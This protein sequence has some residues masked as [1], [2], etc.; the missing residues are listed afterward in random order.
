MGF[1]W[2]LIPGN[3]LA[4]LP[5]V[6]AAL[7][8][9]ALGNY[10]NP[11]LGATPTIDW[12]RGVTQTGTL[13]ADCTLVFTAPHKPGR[14]TLFLTEDGTG[15][16]T[17]TL[18]GNA[19][20]SQ[21]VPPYP[22]AASLSRVLEIDYDGSTYRVWYS[23]SSGDN[24]LPI[25]TATSTTAL[26]ASS[27]PFIE[28]TGTLT[29]QI[30]LPDIATLYKGWSVNIFN[31]STGNVLLRS[32]DG[33]LITTLLASGGHF[34]GVCRATSGSQPTAWLI[35]KVSLTSG[36]VGTL[37][38]ANGGTGEDNSTGGTANT[39]FARPDG[40]TGAAA[41]RA[42]VAADLPNLSGTYQPLNADLTAIAALDATAGLIAKTAAN[43]YARRAIAGT[44]NEITVTNGDGA[45]ANPT[46]S[47]P[48]AMTFT[49][50]TVTGGTYTGAVSFNGVSIGKAYTNTAT[51]GATPSLNLAANQNQSGTITN[52]CTFTFT[53]PTTPCDISILLTANS[54]GGYTMAWPGNVIWADGP[55]PRAVPA[56]ETIEIGGRFDGV[57]HRLGWKP[58]S[59]DRVKITG[60]T[61]TADADMANSSA[62]MWIDDTAGNSAI[63]AKLSDSGGTKKTVT[64][65]MN[66]PRVGSTTSSATPTINT[67]IVDIYRITALAANI[68][69]FTTNLSGT[70]AHG[71]K[72]R[73]EITGTATRTIAWGSSFENGTNNVL[74]T[75]T[76]G[77]EQL[78]VELV[79][80]SATSKWQ[81]ANGE[82][83]TITFS[84]DGGG[85]AITTGAKAV[86][87]V[88]YSHE[89][90]EA[91]LIGGPSGSMV[92]DVWK[93]AYSTSTLPT[94]AN[95]ITASAKP[96]LS[97]A[98]GAQDATLT[99]W[100]K[101]QAAS[102]YRANIDSCST[103]TAATL[104]LKVRKAG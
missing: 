89:I 3:N 101:A 102:S 75:T 71:Q 50:K 96:T 7:Q 56:N 62:E 79:Y 34:H 98:T 85:S 95:T 13:T 66:Q 88:P 49:G 4:D 57:N 51:L 42:I 94:V 81:A 97:S 19:V 16:H 99:G 104:T 70:P 78:N 27:P 10:D 47:L 28:L 60:T 40:G 18:P 46:L 23:P 1:P 25:V 74:P 29:H 90:L 80:N 22:M 15:N 24:Y 103:I 68:T 5:S 63:K 82:V 48:T 11:P 44:A 52:N 84:F 39:F 55:V 21:G 67:D 20:W 54:T 35:G 64:L 8:N 12:T 45:A 32:F 6:A 58:F 91:T 83:N 65:Q 76:I 31:S 43:T 72:L 14:L 41:F 36:V 100:T 73:I 77:T 69:S 26:T 38:K 59:K 87:Y 53:D 61:A 17:I 33:T 30:Y 37:G 93:A 92:V 86:L 9:L 2:P